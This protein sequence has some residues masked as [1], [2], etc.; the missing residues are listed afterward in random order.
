MWHLIDLWSCF[1]FRSMYYEVENCLFFL[2]HWKRSKNGTQLLFR[3]IKKHR[4]WCSQQVWVSWYL[5]GILLIWTEVK[6]CL[7][8]A[9]H[10]NSV[11]NVLISNSKHI[12]EFLKKLYFK[13][14][15][16]LPFRPTGNL[17]WLY[18]MSLCLHL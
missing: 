2:K 3:H 6:H 12:Q 1:I 15:F 7:K 10:N 11:K 14:Q 8:L 17:F 13:L 5:V 9:T 18:T 4:S 16:A